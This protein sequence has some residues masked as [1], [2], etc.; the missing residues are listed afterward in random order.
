MQALPPEPPYGESD[1]RSREDDPRNSGLRAILPVVG[2]IALVAI[3]LGVLGLA[4]PGHGGGSETGDEGYWHLYFPGGSSTS[5]TIGS[6]V[7][8]DGHRIG[9]I[10][11]LV[12]QDSSVSIGFHIDTPTTRWSRPSPASR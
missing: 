12:S 7:V 8:A 5:M 2:V 3:K 4:F 6:A 10:V 9:S 1:Q 11:A